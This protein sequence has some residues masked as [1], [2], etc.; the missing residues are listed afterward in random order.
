MS[1]RWVNEVCEDFIGLVHVPRITSNVITEAI[2]DVLLRYSLPL[3]QCRGQC[4][5][6]ASN[7]MGRLRGVATQ[8][9]VQQKTA[10]SVHC[11][12]QIYACKMQQEIVN[13]LGML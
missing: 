9:Q 6:G 3:V 10:I 11:L 4:Y 7:M 8:I 12:A 5:D 2:K 13:Q 1:I